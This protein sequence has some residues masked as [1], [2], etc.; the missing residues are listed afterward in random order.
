MIQT[1]EHISF[2]M[3]WRI[4]LCRRLQKPLRSMKPPETSALPHL[5]FVRYHRLHSHTRLIWKSPTLAMKLVIRRSILVRGAVDTS[6]VKFRY[7][8]GAASARFS[9]CPDLKA[10]EFELPFNPTATRYRWTTSR[11]P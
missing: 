7:S 4:R 8:P 11:I 5:K 10:A 9:I 1:Y 2:P 3:A 6:H